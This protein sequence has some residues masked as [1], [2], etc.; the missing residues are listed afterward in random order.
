M[1]ERCMTVPADG[2]FVMLTR[3]REERGKAGGTPV[4]EF[5]D[6]ELIEGLRSK[7]K[8]VIKYVYRHFFRQ[9]RSMVTTNSGTSVDAE[10]IFQDTMLILFKKTADGQLIL[11]SS[12]GTYLY[13][14]SRHLWL[15]RLKKMGRMSEYKEL[16]GHEHP[17]EGPDFDRH[18]EEAEKARLFGKHFANLS[19]SDQKVLRLFI[20]R[21]PLAEIASIMGYK[22]YEYA[23][24]RKYIIK[25]KLKSFIMNDPKYREIYQL[26][27]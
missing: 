20:D 1:D 17:D 27:R 19:D 4:L 9:V 7:D 16:A 8:T 3:V 2:G 15:Q 5:S 11:S 25:E 18:A 23:K 13:A 21:V 14:V 12:F 24:T 26:S 6:A 22:S 10:D